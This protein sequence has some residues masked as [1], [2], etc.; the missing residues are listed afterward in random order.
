[1]I[2]K[3]RTLEFILYKLNKYKIQMMVLTTQNHY[4]KE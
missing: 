4:H 1:M 2:K 3:I